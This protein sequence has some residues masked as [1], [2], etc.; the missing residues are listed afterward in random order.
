MSGSAAKASTRPSVKQMTVL[1]RCSSTVRVLGT[2][3]VGRRQ[4]GHPDHR[5]AAVV[6]QRRAAVGRP[7]DGRRVPG[8]GVAQCGT[9]GVLRQLGVEARGQEVEV[10]AHEQLVDAGQDLARVA[11]GPAVR[12]HDRAELAHPRGRVDVVAHDV[13]DDHGHAARRR[14]RAAGTRR[15]SRRPPR[16]RRRPARSSRR[17]RVRAPAAAAGSRLRCRVAAAARSRGEELGVLQHQPGPHGEVADQ[18]E[19][20]VVERWP[21]VVGDHDDAAEDAAAGQQRHGGDA[22]HAELVDRGRSGR[23]RPPR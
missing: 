7:Y 11:A 10:A 2:V 12:A 14:A 21:R 4:R 8:A 17:P 9:R 23:R 20:G 18:R 19:L 15:T 16:P 22:A 1:P 13:A 5:T 3:P 6:E